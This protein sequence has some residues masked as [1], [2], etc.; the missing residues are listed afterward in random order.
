MGLKVENIDF[1]YDNKKIIQDISFEVES[2]EVLGLLGPNGTGKTTLLKCI[3]DLLKNQGICI[4]DDINLKS[5]SLKER[6]KYISYVPQNI[7]LVFPISVFEY[8]K[9]G[10]SPYNSKNSNDNEI[11]LGIIEDFQLEEFAFKGINQLSGGERQRVMIA[12]AMAQEPR[13]ILLDEPT[14]NLDMKHQ[15]K[16]ME[17]LRDISRK[18]DISILISIHDLNLASRYCDKFLILKDTKIF[19]YGDEDKVIDE[20]II[21][22]T[23]GI[24]V[25]IIYH[26]N[27]KIVVMK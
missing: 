4:V 10:R 16:T 17:I 27:R 14:S 23:Y 11:I 15:K 2:G 25:E 18:K 7:D 6:A 12:R 3:L 22:N 21:K 8:I 24:P 1:S 5:L 9:M 26:H 20:D 19:S 13:V